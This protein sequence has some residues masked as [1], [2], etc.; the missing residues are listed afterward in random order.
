MI[1]RPPRSTRT[2]TLFPYTTLFRHPA[3]AGVL[4]RH[5]AADGVGL[6]GPR[7][8]LLHPPRRAHL[9][10]R[11]LG[12][13]RRPAASGAREAAGKTPGKAVFTAIRSRHSG[14][15]LIS[16]GFPAGLPVRNETRRIREG[17]V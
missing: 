5:R 7:D 15:A 6:H 10:P 9:T 4:R 13:L 11:H 16:P 8:V 14:T 1:R 3:A 2:D 17:V 12:S